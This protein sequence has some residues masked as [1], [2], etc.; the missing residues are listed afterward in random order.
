[1]SGAAEQLGLLREALADLEDVLV[2][3]EPTPGAEPSWFGFLL[4][5]RERALHP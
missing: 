3:P 2:L 5:V 4:M 1:M